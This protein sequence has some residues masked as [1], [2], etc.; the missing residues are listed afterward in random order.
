MS[1]ESR[2]RAQA[3]RG[4]DGVVCFGGIDWWY[5]NRGH[6]ECQV[7]TRLAGEMPVLWINSIGLRAPAPGRTELPL[8]RYWRKLKSTLKGLRRDPDSGMWVY[9]PIFVPRYTPG[10][11]RVNGRLLALQITL[12]RWLLGMRRPTV[13]VTPPTAVEPVERMRW[14]QIVF[15]RSDEFSQFPEAD[16][17]FIASLEKRMLALADRVL[18][19]S[20]TLMTREAHLCRSA[21]YLG[22][23]V[24][25][26][27]FSAVR[28]PDGPSP[29]PEALAHLQRPIVGFYG[30]LDDYVIDKDLL[31]ALARRLA[32]RSDPG[33]LLIIGPRAMDTSALEAE[34]NLHYHGQI[35]Y[36]E[37]PRYA[38]SFD[39]AIMPWLA[40]DW[41]ESCN[42]IKLR[43]YLAIGFPI[44]TTDFPEL[45][46]FRHLVEPATGHEAFLAAVERALEDHD[47]ERVRRR[48]A[49][50][51]DATW[52]AITRRV[53]ELI[54][55]G[56]AGCPEENRS[57]QTG[58]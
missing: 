2:E 35:P 40:N 13:W 16:M 53:S 27:R 8:R 32:G 33:T 52:E 45:A 18:Y 28:G 49:A 11:L 54:S 3:F 38:S 29:L 26:D 17:A 20:H 5:H 55:D 43:E 56:P 50:V 58:D 31:V 30:A 12:L 25:Y 15:N 4:S 44:V 22:H 1:P 7:M 14:A 10:W 36:P 47:P 48:R 39:V 6:S 51:R 19:T 9:S 41:I 37:V 34:P 23:G 21:E 57:G 24:D 42:P 46:P